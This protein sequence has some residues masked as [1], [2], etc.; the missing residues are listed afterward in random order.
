MTASMTDSADALRIYGNLSLLEMAPV[1]LAVRHFYQG[2][3]VLEH[4]SVMSLWGKPSDLASLNAAGESDLAANS[5][6]QILRGASLNPDLRILVTVAECP[7][8]IV[9]R[10]SAG[11]N[12]LADLRGKRIGTMAG[13]SAEFCL[14]R[15]LRT[16]GVTTGDVT[17][18]H[19]MAKTA[20][21]LTLMPPAL[22]RGELDAVVLWEPQLQKAV[23]AIGD[24]A[25]V[26]CDPSVYREQFCLCSS[27]AKLEDV[28]LRKKIVAFVRAL[29]AATQGL[30]R[31]PQAA[32][33]LVAEAANLDIETVRDSWPYLAYP[34][35][36]SLQLPD[37]LAQ[38][39][40]WQA[41]HTGRD[42]HTR[43]AL[44]KL[45][46]GSVLSEAQAY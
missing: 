18:V 29:I 32:Q 26:F 46:D 44:E 5:E 35:T 45:I 14:D 40:A 21:P 3:T 6:T 8:R 28:M 20:A 19:H 10:R 37:A 24:D 43:A 31:E 13:S 30:Q 34:A 1:L 27:Q 11:I 15:L 17:I 42:P 9:A 38:A 22:Q 2:E 36:L 23:N 12:S 33:Q 25:I 7:Y 41:R 4:G 39:D 16:V